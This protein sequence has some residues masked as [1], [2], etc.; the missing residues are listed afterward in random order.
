V[1]KFTGHDDLV[2]RVVSMCDD[3]DFSSVPPVSSTENACV[4][5][6]SYDKKAVHYSSPTIGK[7]H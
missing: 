7:L 2:A 6:Q 5:S 1:L 4:C 3:L